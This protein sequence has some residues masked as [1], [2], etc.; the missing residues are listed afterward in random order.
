MQC[1]TKKDFECLAKHKEVHYINKKTYCD[2]K[3]RW[4]YVKEAV[5]IV[6]TEQPTSVL[7]LGPFFTRD[8]KPF[9]IVKGSDTFDC[10]SSTTTYCR[11]ATDIPWPMVNKQYDLFI[12]LQVWEHLEGKQKEAFAEVARVANKAIL[13]FPYKIKGKSTDIH[14]NI[15]DGQIVEWTFG[16]EP[17]NKIV[18][19]D[20]RTRPATRRIVCFFKF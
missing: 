14:A 17:A 2:V 5:R 10:R 18:V 9:P 8:G 16:L 19:V 4:Q 1:V 3:H 7:E 6:N 12:A 13:S 15:D 11:S 20:N